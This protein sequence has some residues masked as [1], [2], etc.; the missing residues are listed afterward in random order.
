MIGAVR[1]YGRFGRFLLV[2]A[3]GFAIDAGGLA[4]LLAAGIDALPARIGSVGL[5]AF[6]TWRLNRAFTFGPSGSAQ[7]V[8]GLRYAF[9]TLASSTLNWCVYASALRLVPGLPPHAGLVA[10][11]AVAMATSYRGYLRFAFRRK[12][13]GAP[14]WMPLRRK[15]HAQ[16]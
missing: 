8:E 3:S 16:F 12:A 5:A 6:A 1:R 2:G 7:P 9:V 13:H 11:S 14:N 4:A 15:E 10:G